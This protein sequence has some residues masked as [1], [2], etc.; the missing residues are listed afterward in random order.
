MIIYWFYILCETKRAQERQKILVTWLN[1][2]KVFH[3]TSQRVFFSENVFALNPI[4]CL[5][6][7][8][9]RPQQRAG[10]ISPEDQRSLIKYGLILD[11]SHAIK[12]GFPVCRA[13]TKQEDQNGSLDSSCFWVCHR[14]IVCFA[15]ESITIFLLSTVSQCFSAHPSLRLR[16]PLSQFLLYNINLYLSNNPQTPYTANNCSN[17]YE[18]HRGDLC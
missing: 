18:P 12:P 11:D 17:I 16:M 10:S 7:F 1:L 13:A 9:L 14:L 15:Q 5:S 8:S 2:A 3:S 4:M 6:N